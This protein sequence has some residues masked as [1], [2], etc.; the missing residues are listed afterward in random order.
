MSYEAIATRLPGVGA[1][2]VCV[3]CATRF[4][5]LGRTPPVCPKCGA[6]QPP[7]APRAAPIRRGP[8]RHVML[9]PVPVAR[10]PEDD[11]APV[12]DPDED[13]EDAD[14]DAA[15]EDADEDEDPILDPAADH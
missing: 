15:E 4:Y 2:R 3:S 12:L 9:K 5:D 14:E 11:A 10:D 6:E 7:I 1:K 8:N 13:E